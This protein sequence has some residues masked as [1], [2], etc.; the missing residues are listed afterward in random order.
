MMLCP[1]SLISSE[2]LGVRN[3][4]VR[5]GH[6]IRIACELAGRLMTEWICV[7]SASSCVIGTA[8][9]SNWFTTIERP[10]LRANQTSPFRHDKFVDQN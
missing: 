6:A 4:T 10:P 1:H 3:W 9:E 7:V 5:C 2:F 8:T